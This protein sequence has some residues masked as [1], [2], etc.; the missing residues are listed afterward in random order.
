MPFGSSA[1]FNG[2]TITSGLDVRH[3]FLD[4]FNSVNDVAI[5]D[6][7]DGSTGPVTLN[8]AS[9]N[10]ALLAIVSGGNEDVFLSHTG[11][12]LSFFGQGTPVTKPTVVGSRGANAALQSLLQALANLGLVLDNSS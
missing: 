5:F 8:F 3:T 9:G 11:G 10:V 1:P 2:G 7:T 4:V 6:G 12:R